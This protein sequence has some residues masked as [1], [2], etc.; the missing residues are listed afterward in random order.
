MGDGTTLAGIA[1]A[2][3]EPTR[4]RVLEILRRGRDEQS[5]SKPHPDLPQ[6]ICPYVDVLPQ[7]IGVT[8]SQLSYHLKMLRE[9]QLVVEHRVGKQVFY[10]V[11]RETLRHFV[12]ALQDQYL[13]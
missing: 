2:L 13:L 12:A 5:M 9:T 7:L 1:A 4:L 6:A 11:N 3:S 10:V 8:R